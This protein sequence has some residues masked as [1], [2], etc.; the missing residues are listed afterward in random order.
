MRTLAV[1]VNAHDSSMLSPSRSATMPGSGRSRNGSVTPTRVVFN[2]EE[3]MKQAL[4]VE[5]RRNSRLLM[6][7]TL[8]P[9]GSHPVMV[10][11]CP[12]PSFD[13]P[14]PASPPHMSADPI[15]LPGSI[16]QTNEG[17]PN[18]GEYSISHWGK[19]PEKLP[20]HVLF[21]LGLYRPPTAFRVDDAASTDTPASTPDSDMQD[22][23]DARANFDEIASYRRYSESPAIEPLTPQESFAASFRISTFDPDYGLES[24]NPY[25]QA[26]LSSRTTQESSETGASGATGTD[27]ESNTGTADTNTPPPTETQDEMRKIWR[28][29]SMPRTVEKKSVTAVSEVV[30]STSR[31]PT[32]HESPTDN[33]IPQPRSLE[34]VPETSTARSTSRR[35][36]AEN[37]VL[38][39]NSHIPIVQPPMARSPSQAS[40]ENDNFQHRMSF[41]QKADAGAA[42]HSTEV[43]KIFFPSLLFPLPRLVSPLL[44]CF[45]PFSF[46]FVRPGA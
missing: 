33:A 40:T 14:L 30:G 35:S 17:F 18:A 11:P 19:G 6:G 27:A 13:K 44:L 28:R 25:R 16:L 26:S 22:A 2:S 1:E 37:V 12:S 10:S 39:S 32:S 3:Q 36:V 43:R 20:P 42:V 24:S 8:L 5:H 38:R 21:E 4:A 34:S 31:T 41:R 45:S 7:E 29:L 9:L 46:A 15:E 23:A